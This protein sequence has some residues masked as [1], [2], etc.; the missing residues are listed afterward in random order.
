VTLDLLARFLVMLCMIG[1]ITI[2]LRMF[3]SKDP[4]AWWKDTN[5]SRRIIV[6]IAIVTQ[7]IVSCAILAQIVN[8]S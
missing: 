6:L 8:P 4:K 5:P 2:S 7:V 3:F 1:V